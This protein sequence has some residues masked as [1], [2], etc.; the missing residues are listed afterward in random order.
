MRCL[1][2]QV[3]SAVLPLA[4]R[5]CSHHHSIALSLVIVIGSLHAPIPTIDR[6]PHRIPSAYVAR[7]LPCARKIFLGCTSPAAGPWV[8]RP[9]K[10]AWPHQPASPLPC[11]LGP[12]FADSWVRRSA[13][14][15]IGPCAGSRLP[16]AAWRDGGAWCYTFTTLHHRA[17]HVHH[18]LGAAVDA[19]VSLA[20][21]Q[22]H[23]LSSCT[24]PTMGTLRRSGAAWGR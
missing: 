15:S 10:P 13:S 16:E 19:A 12:R 9:C 8:H 6:C 20:R 24:P 14:R 21:A 2:S 22:G 3:D 11:T 7:R 1:R 23:T 5:A 17:K 4:C 18:A